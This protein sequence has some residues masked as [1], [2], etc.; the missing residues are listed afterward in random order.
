MQK[1]RTK[2]HAGDDRDGPLGRVAK[3]EVTYALGNDRPTCF[4][5]AISGDAQYHP[6]SVRHHDHERQTHPR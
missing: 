3:R 5:L 2:G 4:W 1:E 6:T